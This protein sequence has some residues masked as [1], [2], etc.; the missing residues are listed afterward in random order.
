M[1]CRKVK[2]YLEQ[3]ADEASGLRMKRDIREH[4]AA[5]G[6]C[7]NYFDSLISYHKRLNSLKQ[8]RAPAGFL[9]EINRRIDEPSFFRKTVNLLFFPLKIK[10]SLEA[11]GALASVMIILYSYNTVKQAERAPFP[12]AQIERRES[13][14]KLRDMDY[15]ARMKAAES[16][17]PAGGTV[18][19]ND[20]EKR[21]PP[22]IAENKARP[23]KLKKILLPG[24]HVGNAY[25]IALLVVPQAP[26]IYGEARKDDLDSNHLASSRSMSDE[27]A[28]LG[29]APSAIYESRK[30]QAGPAE[31]I[32]EEQAKSEVEAPADNAKKSA[33]AG[34]P[35]K[36]TIDEIKA[37]TAKLGGKILSGKYNN[38][39]K[40]MEYIILEIP[41]WKYPEFI[42]RLK[43][44]GTL[45]NEAPEKAQKGQKMQEIKVLLINQ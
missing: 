23:P 5:C 13:S 35:R 39:T 26:E 2:K 27:K 24:S 8:H 22:L 25:E 14:L 41:S 15:K 33:P 31:T 18:L 16:I 28:P 32:K 20:T 36:E 29:G 44:L 19:K 21:Q 12:L 4:I 1:K 45:Q 11:A 17:T 38:Q 3:N 43:K 37:A 30:E 7:M 6:E 40:E 34:K 10:V 42:N 9:A